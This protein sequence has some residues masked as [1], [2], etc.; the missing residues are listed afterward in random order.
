MSLLKSEVKLSAVNEIGCRLDDVLENATQ[1]LYRAEGSVSAL[2]Q[3]V[4]SL[5]NLLKILDKEL[6]DKEVNLESCGTIKSYFNRSIAT[7]SNLVSAAE[8][9][10]QTQ[11]GKIQGFQQAV[12]VAKKYKDE[13]LNKL[14]VLQAAIQSNAEEKEKEPQVS[15]ES[16]QEPQKQIPPRPVGVRPGPSIKAQRLAEQLKEVQENTDNSTPVDGNEKKEE[17]KKIKQKKKQ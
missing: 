14:H 7:V 10:R 16:T 2:K 13:E 11:V 6:N 4:S 12:Q 3:A 9:N 8:T 17:L 15:V 5:E 1:D